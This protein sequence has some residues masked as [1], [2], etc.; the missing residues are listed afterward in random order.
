MFKIGVIYFLRFFQLVFLS[1]IS[2]SKEFF[3]TFPLESVIKYFRFLLLGLKFL[4]ILYKAFSAAFLKTL[5]LTCLLEMF[6]P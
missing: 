3:K 1:K 6:R 5:K 4:Q 2:R